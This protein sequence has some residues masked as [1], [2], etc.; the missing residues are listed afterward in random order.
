M[1]GLKKKPEKQLT[2]LLCKETHFRREEIEKLIQIFKKLLIDTNKNDTLKQ[3]SLKLDR[4]IFRDILHNTFHMTDDMLMDR[5]FRAFDKDSD[6]YICLQEWVKGLSVFLQGTV[7][8]KTQYCFDVYDLNSDGYI[9]REEMFHMLKNSMVKQ[10]TEE[11]PDEGI[12]DLV[13]LTLKKMDHDHD[14]RLSYK[15]F[16]SSVVIEPL[17][18]EAFGQCLPD[19]KSKDA[20]VKTFSDCDGQQADTSKKGKK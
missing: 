11:D 9:S 13:E 7:D 10:P 16:K 15:D 5:V 18:L 8:E 14:G 19:N 20:F 17:L 6:S 4:T 2:D 12:K 1:S 3:E